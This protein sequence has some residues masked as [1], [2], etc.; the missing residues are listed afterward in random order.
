MVYK[1]TEFICSF[2]HG[3]F[4]LLV[5]FFLFCL[6]CCFMTIL[7]F[8][9]KV[10]LSASSDQLA[11][12]GFLLLC[13]N[14]LLSVVPTH[15]W[16]QFYQNDKLVQWTLK[17]FTKPFTGTNVCYFLFQW[18]LGVIIDLFRFSLFYDCHIAFSFRI[19]LIFLCCPVHHYS[20]IPPCPDIADRVL[21]YQLQCVLYKF[22]CNSCGPFLFLI[23]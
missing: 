16:F 10:I 11:S 23:S 2:S 4:C 19:Y 14:F 21:S 20:V 13:L 3:A 7:L 9:Y 18:L 1:F 12:S 6:F 5:F 17:V 22:I 15:L 8:L